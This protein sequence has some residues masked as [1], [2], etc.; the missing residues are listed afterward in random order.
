MGIL[1]MGMLYGIIHI[2]RAGW[3]LA[4]DAK[5]KGRRVA[6]CACFVHD[7]MKGNSEPWPYILTA[8]NQ[9]GVLGQILASVCLFP[10]LIN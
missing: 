5:R 2:R 4:S 7:A 3:D 10:F 6:F 1:Y 9:L 8:A